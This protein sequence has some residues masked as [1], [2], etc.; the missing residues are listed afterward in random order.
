MP[1]TISDKSEIVKRQ[2]YTEAFSGSGACVRVY[3]TGKEIERAVRTNRCATAVDAG[4][5][6]GVRN[7]LFCNDDLAFHSR[8]VGRQALL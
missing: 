6:S 3:S 2:F 5:A 4:I 1:H 8:L 7:S